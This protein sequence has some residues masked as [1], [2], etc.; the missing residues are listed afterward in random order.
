VVEENKPEPDFES[1]TTILEKRA[2][3]LAWLPTIVRKKFTPAALWTT[4]TVLCVAITSLVSAQ[5]DVVDLKEKVATLQKERKEALDDQQAE[6][7]LLHKIDT[8]VAVMAN[9]VATIA[10]EVDHQR[11]WREKIE[12]VAENPPHARRRP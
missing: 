9:Q 8:Q 3:G 12:S 10:T 7:E 5:H 11:E 6:R 1:T 2:P 4:I